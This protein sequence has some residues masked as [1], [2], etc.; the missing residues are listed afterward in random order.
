MGGG[1]F[2]PAGMIRIAGF[3]AAIVVAV[4][5]Y[6]GFHRGGETIYDGRWGV[7]ERLIRPIIFGANALELLALVFA[8][9]I[10]WRVWKKMQS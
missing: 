1:D 6:I 8:G 5:V 10:A 9:L 4:A 7:M 3:G 2:N